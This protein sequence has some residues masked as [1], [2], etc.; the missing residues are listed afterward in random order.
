MTTTNDDPFATVM[1]GVHEAVRKSVLM[2]TL[3]SELECLSPATFPFVS[4]FVRLRDVIAP[5]I[6]DTR[7][8]FPEF[9]PHDEALHVVKLFQLADKLF[10][11]AYHQLKGPRRNNSLFSV[12]SDLVVPLGEI[13]IFLDGQ[14]LHFCVGNLYALLIAPFDQSSTDTQTRTG[15]GC[16]GVLEDGFEA[17]QR[18]TCPVFAEF[19]EQA[20]LDRIPLRCTG[21]VMCDGDGET[22]AI[23]QTMLDS[24]LPG[25]AV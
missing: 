24:V 7:I 18:A 22:V 6:N 23:A 17:V 10:K 13:V 2:K 5:H 4:E 16:T 15:C 11:P 1:P 14:C 9:T 25:A 21:R 20:V 19:A 3:Y 12:G 8:L